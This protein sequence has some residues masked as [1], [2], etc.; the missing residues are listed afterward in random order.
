MTR[1][2]LIVGGTILACV[3]GIVP[4]AALYYFSRNRALELEHEHLTRYARWT[5][6]RAQSTLD[7]AT[8]ALNQL[9]PRHFPDCSREH[10]DAMR[11]AVL[12][13]RTV[14][15]MGFYVNGSVVCTSWGIVDKPVPER[16]ANY[17]T[18]SGIGIRVR[19]APK[20]TGVPRVVTMA[21]RSHFAQIDANLMI[22]IPTE[23]NMSL[24]LADGRGNVMAMFNSPAV[25][26][27]RQ[28]IVGA[29]MGKVGNLIYSSF[30]TPDWVGVAI[31]DSSYTDVAFRRQRFYLLPLG[32][33][34]AA[35]VAGSVIVA[36]RH[37]LS[38]V[39]ELQTA[40]RKREFVAYYQPIV[41]LET[42][43]CVGAEALVRWKQPDG[44]LMAPDLFIPLA[45]QSGLIAGITDLVIQ[46]VVRNMGRLLRSESGFHIAIN[47]SAEDA[48][49][50]RP[51]DSLFAILRAN[52]IN[53]SRIW[54]EVT[55][56]AFMHPDVARKSLM[57]A[58]RNGHSILIDDFG[59]GYSSL[60]LLSSLPLD[61]LKI[62][63]SFVDAIGTDSATSLVTPHII[64]MA[65]QLNLQLIAE[66]IEMEDQA[67]FCRRQGVQFGQG[68][69]FARAMPDREF[70][71][72]FHTH[73]TRRN[74][75]SPV[76]DRQ[77]ESADA[78]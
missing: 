78:T 60:S 63:K 66:G 49:T 59:T 65:C 25:G 41:E 44:T 76:S 73:R 10:I 36:L 37:R 27:V 61:I 19:S 54:L 68:W 18:K 72:Y 74:A 69:L 17:V 52:N 34:L 30:R 16:P 5:V 28:A 58:R 42:G 39:A 4:P 70:L 2:Q 53:P 6:Q 56:R 20:A 26:V 7:D 64:E 47:L 35:I 9:E 40:I 8:S 12:L 29:P 15:E 46:D 14:D 23:N 75:V 1:L 38:P 11:D 67:A 50:G 3:S 57:R 31:E 71:R 48:E 21:S 32:L 77:G 33:V 43:R 55:E 24:A 62:D 45:E 13:H 22:D 51:L